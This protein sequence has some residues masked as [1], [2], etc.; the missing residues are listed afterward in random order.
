MGILANGGRMTNK[1][2]YTSKLVDGKAFADK[3]IMDRISD[4]ETHETAYN[5]QY[6]M[7]S[8]KIGKVLDQVVS[9]HGWWTDS[10]GNLNPK[11][12]DFSKVMADYLESPAGPTVNTTTR[13]ALGEGYSVGIVGE[14]LK[15]SQEKEKD[16]QAREQRGK[17]KKQIEELQDGQ[18]RTTK[19][20]LDRLRRPK[21]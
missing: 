3:M 18:R 9:E 1:G 4:P 5:A 13:N 11:Y 8:P 16:R 14:I 19:K 2:E 20:I 21:K 17:Q 10:S 12:G 6:V 7:S 15:E